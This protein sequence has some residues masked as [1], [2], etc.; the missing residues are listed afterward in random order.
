MDKLLL[1]IVLGL[2]MNITWMVIWYWDI[3]SDI[4]VERAW[5]E[6]LRAMK[7]LFLLSYF[8]FL[9]YYMRVG[10]LSHIW[11]GLECV[12]QSHIFTISIVESSIG[13]VGT[14]K[15]Y[16]GVGWGMG[17]NRNS[18]E[19]LQSPRI[20]LWCWR[21]N[22]AAIYDVKGGLP[23]VKIV[24]TGPLCSGPLSLWARVSIPPVL[25]GSSGLIVWSVWAMKVQ[26]KVGDGL[27]ALMRR[28][29]I[30]VMGRMVFRLAGLLP[31]IGD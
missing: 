12:R 4:W 22:W 2:G 13:E 7:I 21:C 5:V 30:P 14:N 24:S 28:W 27:L 20:W 19:L 8:P 6:R 25:I 18:C 3:S 29:R 16:C 31:G 11:A 10:G 9:S 15:C 23:P 17:W 1:L 26:R